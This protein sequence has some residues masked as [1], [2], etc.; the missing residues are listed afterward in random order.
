MNCKVRILQSNFDTLSLQLTSLG[1]ISIYKLRRITM[2]WATYIIRGYLK[3]RS[4]PRSGFRICR[5][6]NASS[7]MHVDGA[8]APC[9]MTNANESKTL[10][11]GND[12]VARFRSRRSWWRK[13]GGGG[14]TLMPHSHP[15]SLVLAVF[16]SLCLIAVV[17]GAP[18]PVRGH[19]C[20]PSRVA[21]ESL[22][23]FL[24]PLRH[25]ATAIFLIRGPWQAPLIK[26]EE[27]ARHEI[28]LVIECS[29]DTLI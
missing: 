3:F 9:G 7:R 24:R 10:S 25:R 4:E 27:Q 29:Y 6:A 1:F 16:F 22:H 15:Y 18:R 14:I 13:R 17:K 28:P 23:F 21:Y 12:Q 5:W 19:A 2:T 11:R 26:A 20:V 8:Q